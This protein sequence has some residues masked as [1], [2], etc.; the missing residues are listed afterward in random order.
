[1]NV[2]ILAPA[3]INLG[4][5]ILDKRADGYHNVDM[6]MQSVSLYDVLNISVSKNSFFEIKS[7]ADF[8][9]PLEDNT[10]YKAAKSFFEFTGVKP[11]EIAIEIQ[12]NIPSLAGLAGGSSDG[13]A[14]IVAL[15]HI[16]ETGLPLNDLMKIGEKVGSDVPFCIKGGTSEAGGRGTILHPINSEL[17]YYLVIVKPD[18]NIST[19]TAYAKAESIEEKNILAIERINAALKSGDLSGMCN[20]LFNRFEDV[21]EDPEVFLLKDKMRELGAKGTLMTGSGSAVFGIFEDAVSAQRCQK[22]MKQDYEKVFLCKPVSHG[23]IIDN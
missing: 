1:M 8:K 15:N 4:L 7:N 23:V 14:V 20:N 17:E 5:E 11:A 10:M 6:I 13:A 16:F 12:K 18:I 9:C 21:V 22:I 3:K 2:K 19:S